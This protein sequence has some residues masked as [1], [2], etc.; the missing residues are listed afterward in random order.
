MRNT[1]RDAQDNTPQDLE[2]QNPMNFA[3]GRETLNAPDQDQPKSDITT[4]SAAA[5]DLFNLGSQTSLIE[6]FPMAAYAVRAP[7]GVI[8][9]FNSRAAEL[10][11]R[12][13]AVGDTD[14]RFCGAYKLFHADGTHMAHCDTPV[15]LALETGASVHEQE[16]I[17]E[18][19]DGSRVTVSVHID[20]IRDR[21]GAI[22]GVVNFFHDIHE[23]KLAERTTGLLAAIV[24]SSDD[25]IVSESL[26]GIITSWNRSAERL[27]G[28]AA[29]EAIGQ[30]ITIIVP[31]GRQSEEVAIL[32]RLDRGERV[33]HF[34]TIRARKDGTTL[35]IALTISPVRDAAGRV[36]GA[37]K[38]ARDITERKRAERALAEQARLL[39]LSSDAIFVRDAADRITYWNRAAWGLY[40]YTREEALGRVTHDLLHTA[41]PEPLES[42][43]KQLDRDDHWTGELVHLKKDST[44][45]VVVSRWTLDRDGHGNPRSIL[46]TNTDITQRKQA[47][48]AIKENEF[49]ARLLRL[50][51]EERRRIARELHDGVG[52]LL[53]A[54]SMNVSKVKKEGSRLSP[55]AA[56]CVEENSN[57]IK[58]ISADIRTMSY[59]FHPPLLDELGLESAL[60]WYVE[61]FA[62]RSKIA[63]NLELPVDLGRLPKDQEMCL[64]RLVQECLTNIHRHSG[65]STALVRLWRTPGEIRME[66][67]DE[68]RGIH[69][70]IQSKVASGKSAGVGLRGM[71]ERVK[72]FDGTLEIHSNGKGTSILVT[73]PL[74][75]EAVPPDES[76]AHSAEDQD[77]R[78][79]AV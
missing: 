45:I 73:L 13:P 71:R 34:E 30:H 8:A 18:K 22:V 4:R 54:M 55:D 17:I 58:Q 26:D 50:Q 25:A 16:V 63:A 15:A 41:F 23:R 67:S 79:Q 42:I 40:G 10:W 62:E 56:R 52:Q 65:S 14:E 49:S 59:L 46:E 43:R 51:D 74:T 28:Y 77:S 29:E 33:E 78:S 24:D 31:P 61:G 72:Q 57:M 60:K 53:A 1:N 20:P 9:W 70:E 76:N 32:E 39:D 47:E 44:Q 11:G 5:S 7:D 19:P 3:S 37:S 69:Q 35:D 36:V 12:V 27:F 48:Q 68:G 64:F 66:V 21:D 75:E 2:G 6:L 38:V